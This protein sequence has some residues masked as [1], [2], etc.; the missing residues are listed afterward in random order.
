MEIK[1]VTS[2]SFRLYGRIINEYDYDE[3][4]KKLEELTDMPGDSVIYVPSVPEL[5]ATQA[6]EDL[7]NNCLEACL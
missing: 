3:M 1:P 4:L 2:E 7:S 5:E 6:Y